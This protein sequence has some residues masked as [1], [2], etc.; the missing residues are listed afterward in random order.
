MVA[1]PVVIIQNY[2]NLLVKFLLYAAAAVEEVA[3]A[4]VAVEGGSRPNGPGSFPF[5]GLFKNH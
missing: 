5:E 4:A 2:R 3:G 1:P